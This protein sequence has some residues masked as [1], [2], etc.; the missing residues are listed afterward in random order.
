[1]INLGLH[2]NLKGEYVMAEPSY[3]ASESAH[4]PGY[5]GHV[6][7]RRVNVVPSSLLGDLFQTCASLILCST[8]NQDEV[9]AQRQ[10]C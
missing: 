9:M 1:M 10:L 2:S 8:L 3:L 5:T 6:A 4:V 7:M